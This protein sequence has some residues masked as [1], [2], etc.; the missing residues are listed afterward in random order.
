M[1]YRVYFSTIT[2]M[3]EVAIQTFNV[4]ATFL[5]FQGPFA[6]ILV[7]SSWYWSISLNQYGDIWCEIHKL[8]TS[9]ASVVQYCLNDS[10]K[11]LARKDDML[12]YESILRHLTVDEKCVLS[13]KCY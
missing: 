2:S 8:G 9:F 6:V 13:R 10:S 5:H 4:L 12:S 7:L 3:E 1:S 11:K